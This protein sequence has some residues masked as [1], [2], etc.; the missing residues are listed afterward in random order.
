MI[1]VIRYTQFQNHAVVTTTDATPTEIANIP[2]DVNNSGLLLV[3][4][5]SMVS[6]GSAAN[7]GMYAVKYISGL[8]IG[9]KQTVFEDNGV[10]V[11]VTFADDGSGNISVKGTGVAA[12]EITWICRTQVLDQSIMASL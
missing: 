7:I 8:T 6:D 2:V 1:D 5:H 11:S 4:V 9:T 10:V 3:Y 12:T